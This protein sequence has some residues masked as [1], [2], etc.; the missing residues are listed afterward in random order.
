MLLRQSFSDFSVTYAPQTNSY[1][2]TKTVTANSERRCTS[3]RIFD[4]S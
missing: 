4:R 2:N 1:V 3:I